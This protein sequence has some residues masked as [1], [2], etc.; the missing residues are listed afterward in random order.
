MRTIPIPY[1]AETGELRLCNLHHRTH[2][3]WR[4]N[5][6]LRDCTGPSPSPIHLETLTKFTDEPSG[7]NN[8]DLRSSDC[9]QEAGNPIRIV[10][11]IG[12]EQRPCLAHVGFKLVVKVGDLDGMR[13]KDRYFEQQ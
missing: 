4:R 3:D 1:R 7:N 9:D 2:I 10:S 8:Q 6:P 13:L 11:L 12:L 5:L